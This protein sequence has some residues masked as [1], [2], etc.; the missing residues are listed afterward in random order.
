MSK[1][2]TISTWNS[3][4]FQWI[5]A[6]SSEAV[7]VSRKNSQLKNKAQL[8]KLRQQ[9]AL[10]CSLVRKM[11][12]RM[13][14]SGIFLGKITKLHQWEGSYFVFSSWYFKWLMQTWDW[15]LDELGKHEGMAPSWML[16]GKTW[17][18]SERRRRRE[19]KIVQCNNKKLRHCS[20]GMTIGCMSSK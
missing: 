16:P 8:R 3:I 13:S 12:Q 14:Q 4:G 15:P 18:S 19:G 7:T 10:Q 6:L 17:I 1:Q 5:F 11:W 20:C 9:R 2:K